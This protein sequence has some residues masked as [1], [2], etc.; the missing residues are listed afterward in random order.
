MLDDL[1][2]LRAAD[3]GGFLDHLGALPGSYDGPAGKRPGPYGLTGFGE[4]DLLMRALE[5]WVDAPLVASGTQFLLASGFDFGDLAPLKLS[6]E[7]TQADPIV[8]GSEA[9]APDF[10]IPP[11]VLSPYTYAGYL[12]HATGQEAA[13]SAAERA[14]GELRDAFS[15]ERPTAANPAKALAWALLNRVPLLL[16][17][18][19]DAHAPETWQRLLGRVGKTLAF[20]AGTHP[21]EVL[22][23]AFEARHV[24]AD[25]VV[26]VVLGEGDAETKLVGEILSTRAAQLEPFPLPLSEPLTDPGARALALWYAG[27]WV[28]AYLALLQ[29]QSPEDS[30]VY[31]R[32]QRAAAE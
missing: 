24:L 30:P 29:G 25:D 26:A 7:L 5:S 11:G 21:A 28:A 14:L 32:A 27:L 19:A 1:S 15:P 17:G 12:A 16:A 8:L 9:Y 18:R 6:L 2:R 13:L 4:A 20:T 22:T 23:G 31:A 10:R 3:P